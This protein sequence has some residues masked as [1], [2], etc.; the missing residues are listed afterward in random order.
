VS[1]RFVLLEKISAELRRS[2]NLLLSL[3]QKN[4]MILLEHCGQP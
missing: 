2:D 4:N 1:G 3:V